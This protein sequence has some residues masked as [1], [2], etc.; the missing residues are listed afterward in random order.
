MA[1]ENRCSVYDSD[2]Y[3]YPQSVEDE[4]VAGI[5]SIY[6]P[7]TGECFATTGET[8]IEHIVARSEAR[9]SGM[10]A[11]SGDTKRA[12]ARTFST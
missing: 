5:G 12:F 2:D 6:S 9:D 11:A 7:Y 8:D 3:S 4:I 1:P 10:C